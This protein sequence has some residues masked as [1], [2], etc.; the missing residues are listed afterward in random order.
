MTDA[1]VN[2][3]IRAVARLE[4]KVSDMGEKFDGT[5]AQ[6]LVE[7]NAQR[8]RLHKLE[9]DN[10]GAI[11]AK[12]A[13][14]AA[15]ASRIRAQQA[16]DEAGSAEW[17]RRTRWIVLVGVLVSAVSGVFGLLSSLSVV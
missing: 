12:A 6:I 13:L 16:R 2:E 8:V 17:S 4:Q 14:E 7:S 3:L 1:V 9:N 5:I 15:E 11:A 10:V